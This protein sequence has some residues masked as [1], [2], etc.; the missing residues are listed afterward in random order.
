MEEFFS[1]ISVTASQQGEAGSSD[2]WAQASAGLR[3]P[4]RG[5]PAA[6]HRHRPGS[7]MPGYPAGPFSCTAARCLVVSTAKRTLIACSRR[8]NERELALN[9]T[10]FICFGGGSVCSI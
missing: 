6:S 7:P 3:S 1:Q 4:V 8:Q 10:K 5:P 2:A 9:Y